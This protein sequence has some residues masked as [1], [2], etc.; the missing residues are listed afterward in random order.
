MPLKGM[1]VCTAATVMEMHHNSQEHNAA[2]LLLLY[3]WNAKLRNVNCVQQLAA[4]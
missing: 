4:E 1:C 2:Q 3:Q